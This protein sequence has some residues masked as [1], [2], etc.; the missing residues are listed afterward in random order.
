MRIAIAGATGT[1]GKHVARITQ[2][3]GHQVVP[4]SRTAGVD[5]VTGR[6]V[7]EALRGADAVIDV[8]SVASAATDACVAFFRDSST[9]LLAAE[10]AASVPH[11]VA[12]SIVGIDGISSGYYAGKNAQE[13][14]VTT[15]DAPWTI[16]RATQFHEFAPQMLTQT[17]FGPVAAVPV[18]RLQPVAAAEVASALVELAEGRPRGRVTDLAGPRQESLVDMARRYLR[19]TGRRTPVIPLR[20]PGQMFRAMRDGSVLPGPGATLGSQTFDE[21]LKQLPSQG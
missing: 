13:R 18:G 17:T 5:I 15:S 9:T 4:M 3:R 16:L 6:G 21:W 20:M 19:A 8:A 11:H 12:L 2:E 1:L 10:K 7:P 14:V